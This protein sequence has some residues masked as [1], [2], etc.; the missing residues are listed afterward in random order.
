[1]AKLIDLPLLQFFSKEL[2]VPIKNAVSSLA[3]AVAAL[4]DEIDNFSWDDING[5]PSTFTPSSHNHDSSYYTKAE[6]DSL[7]T[8]LQSLISSV[9]KPGGSKTSSELVAGLLIS[10]NEGKVYNISDTIT[11][12]SLNKGL[13]VENAESSYP[14]GTNVVVI[15]TVPADNNNPA[16][17]KFDVLSGFIDLSNYITD[18]QFNS[19]IGTASLATTAQTIKEA[20][21]EINSSGGGGGSG[22]NLPVNPS[23]TTNINTWIET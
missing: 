21:N 17:Y 5:K 13:F 11:L 9:Y 2:I 18:S 22:G 12:T 7:L 4:D 19:I 6:V 1:M 10:E 8:S 20:I 15:E 23:D 16:T 14:P 3:G